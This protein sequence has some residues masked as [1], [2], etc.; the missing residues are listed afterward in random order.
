MQVTVSYPQT[1]A[2]TQCSVKQPHSTFI[3][4]LFSK[5]DSDHFFIISTLRRT[6]CFPFAR[7]LHWVTSYS[8]SHLY[9]NLFD[10]IL[11]IVSLAD[12]Q[13]ISSFTFQNHYY[14]SC[15]ILTIIP[16]KQTGHNLLDKHNHVL[17]FKS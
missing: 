5:R 13:N 7:L 10:L 17:S 11:L 3:F 15:F 8:L 14:T 1:T 9:S 2:S 16:A 4:P 6:Y 12:A